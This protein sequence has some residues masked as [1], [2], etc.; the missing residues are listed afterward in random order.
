MY[1]TYINLNLINWNTKSWTASMNE[2]QY[3]ILIQA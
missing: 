3:K 1:F 2:I